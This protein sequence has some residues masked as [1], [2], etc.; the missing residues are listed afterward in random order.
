MEIYDCQGTSISF[1]EPTLLPEYSID[2]FKLAKEK[3]YYNTF[4]T[5]GYMTLES[6]KALKDAGLDAMNID[7]K[8]DKDAVK[9]YCG[10]D[11]DKVW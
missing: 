9:E 7:I 6:L 2:V 1:N 3:G 4:V 11:I 5:N 10:A 8:G